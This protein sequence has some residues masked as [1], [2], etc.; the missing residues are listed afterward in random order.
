MLYYMHT[1][2]FGMGRRNG[3]QKRRGVVLVVHQH[4]DVLHQLEKKSARQLAWKRTLPEL[5]REIRKTLE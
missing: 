1:F 4:D 5:V 3:C 2:R